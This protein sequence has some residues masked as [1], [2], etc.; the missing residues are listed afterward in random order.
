MHSSKFQLYKK[1]LS[2]KFLQKFIPIL[3]GRRNF[4][5]LGGGGCYIGVR[6]FQRKTFNIHQ[7]QFY[8]IFF[9]KIP[10]H[11]FR[12]V[13]LLLYFLIS[14]DFISDFLLMNISSAI[15]IFQ[16]ICLVIPTWNRKQVYLLLRFMSKV[17]K[18]TELVLSTDL[19]NKE[20]VR[21]FRPITISKSLGAI[22]NLNFPLK[23]YL[24]RGDENGKFSHRLGYSRKYPLIL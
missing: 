3:L 23:Y 18:N 16:F 20:M 7:I 13:I 22:F 14:S 8:A 24:P 6:L 12:E 1:S 15:Q 10:Y 19:P 17:S 11:E 5:W 21:L 4:S 9:L 2:W